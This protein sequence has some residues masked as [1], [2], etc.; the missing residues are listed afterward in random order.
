MDVLEEVIVAWLAYF[1]INGL[2]FF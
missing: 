1:G 2:S